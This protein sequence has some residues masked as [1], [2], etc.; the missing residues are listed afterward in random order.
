MQPEGADRAETSACLPHFARSRLPAVQLTSADT[1]SGNEFATHPGQWWWILDL[2]L[3]TWSPDERS[4]RRGLAATAAIIWS[5][6]FLFGWGL[7]QA[8]GF[9]STYACAA[10]FAVT[11]PTALLVARPAFARLAPDLIW[12][13]D[14]NTA[15]RIEARGVASQ[16]D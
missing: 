12:R 14:Q 3:G 11:L 4:A 7:L 16:F 10:A 6:L 9:D 8:Q 15:L 13:A 1:T 2:D 5:A